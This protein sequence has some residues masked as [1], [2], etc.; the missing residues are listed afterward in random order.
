MDHIIQNI[1]FD[2]SHV[3]SGQWNDIPKIS[4][5]TGEN[6][7]GKTTIL[8]WLMEKYRDKALPW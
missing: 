5:I 4:I 8:Q 1:D 6:G 3:I 2:I 7:S